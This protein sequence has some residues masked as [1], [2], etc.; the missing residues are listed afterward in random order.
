MPKLESQNV[1]YVFESVFSA[2]LLTLVCLY[3]CPD[4]IIWQYGRIFLLRIPKYISQES[5]TKTDGFIHDWHKSRDIVQNYIGIFEIDSIKCQKFW[6][7]RTYER[8][9]HNALQQNS[10]SHQTMGLAQARPIKTYTW[11]NFLILIRWEQPVW[12]DEIH[13]YR[14]KEIQCKFFIFFNIYPKTFLARKSLFLLNKFLYY[15]TK[16]S[17]WKDSLHVKFFHAR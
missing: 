8:T 10:V 17:D 15:L 2:L 16:H 6:A 12:F 9:H 7:K 3:W 1:S 11:K 14:K 5:V 13:E 4:S